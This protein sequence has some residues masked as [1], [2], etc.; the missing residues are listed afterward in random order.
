M[1]RL[2]KFLFSLLIFLVILVVAAVILIPMLVDPNDYKAEIAAEVKKATGRDLEMGGEIGLSVFPWLGLELNQVRLSNA[3]GFGDA[4][5]AALDYVQVRAKLLP[6]LQKQVEVDKIRIQGLELNLA[7][8]A[9]GRSNWDDLAGAGEAEAAEPAAAAPETGDQQEIGAKQVLGGLAIGGVELQDSRVVWDDQAA[10]QRYEIAELS[11]DTEA[12][13]PGQPLDLALGFRITGSQPALKARVDLDTQVQTDAGLKQIDLLPLN[14]ELTQIEA[15]GINGDM[16]LIGQVRA[17]LSTQRFSVE[18]LKFTARVAGEGLP[19][20]GAA[21]ELLA[22]L[23]LD[24]AAQ[25]LDLTGMQLTSGRLALSGEAHGTQ[26]QTAPAFQGDLELAE[27]SPRALLQDLGL[28]APET[29]DP[30]VLNKAAASFHLSSTPDA[31]N[32]ERVAMVLDDSRLDGQLK[33]LDPARP[34]IRFDFKVDAIDLD[35]YLPPAAEEGPKAPLPPAG[36]PADELPAGAPQPAPLFPVETLRQLDV[37]GVF[38]IGQ[39]IIQKLKAQDVSLSLESK[40]GQLK[41][42][43]QVQRFYD[44][45]LKGSFGLDVRGA[46]PKLSIV[47]RLDKVQAGP[48]LADLSGKE[49]LTGT[50]RFSANLSASGQHQQALMQSLG[51]KLDLAFLKG[52]VKGFNLARTVREVKAR[53][54]GEALPPDNQPNQTDFSELTGSAVITKGVV[55]NQDLLAKSPFLRVTGEGEA[56]LPAEQLDYTVKAVVVSTEKGQGGEGLEELKGVPIPV[57]MRGPFSDIDY[58]VDIKTVLVETQGA[59]ID[60]KIDDQLDKALGD[61][62]DEQTKDQVKGLLKGFLR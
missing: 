5:F 55:V 22:D 51:G 57:R 53:V 62:V 11:L 46:T 28:D 52:A 58:E 43:D 29:S 44:G 16:G 6:L 3:P 4:P 50:A 27:F 23:A 10:G 49:Q 41:L 25:T 18:G 9:D 7:R 24:L 42:E 15:E 12:F 20:A 36:Q 38:R 45:S 35:R 26:I 2:F 32:L 21:L 37:Q 31:V 60:E 39:L 61:K 34:A 1:G 47:Q 14:L 54:K 13:V 33:L 19:P 17:D 30:A 59:K 56:D 40:G 8:A 48:L